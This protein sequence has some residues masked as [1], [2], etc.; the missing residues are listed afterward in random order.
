M[1]NQNEMTET[2]QDS[3]PMIELSVRDNRKNASPDGEKHQKFTVIC[4]IRSSSDIAVRKSARGRRNIAFFNDKPERT[5]LFSADRFDVPKAGAY[6]AY[7]K[8]DDGNEAV[9]TIVI[10][11]SR[12]IIIL[13][14]LIILIGLGGIYGA[15]SIFPHPGGRIPTLAQ[16]IEGGHA[17]TGLGSSET[18]SEILAALKKQQV[19]VTDNV[20]TALHF[21]TGG[22]GA[23]G[24][25]NVANDK[26]NNVI[27]QAIVTIGGKEVAKSVPIYPDEHID[28]IT[29]S[30]FLNQGTYDAVAYINYYNPT[31]K[32][33]ISKAGYKVKLTVG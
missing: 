21:S 27:M 13:I 6:T 31:T 11:R 32:V 17:K 25:W 30:S 18:D 2:R 26:S 16:L 33:Y 29:L 9:E 4:N 23:V 8:D 3:I 22:V 14:P 12:L 19:M 1:E 20:G 10:P 28:S 5:R 24:K 15:L 7:I